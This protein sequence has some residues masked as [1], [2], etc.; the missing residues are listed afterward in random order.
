MC[1]ILSGVKV[2]N[3]HSS[4][5]FNFGCPGQ[6]KLKCPTFLIVTGR[7]RSMLCFVIFLACVLVNNVCCHNFVMIS[8]R[9]GIVPEASDDGKYYEKFDLDYGPT[10]DKVRHAGRMAGVL[11][12]GILGKLRDPDPF[13]SWLN[14]KLE[15]GP[16]APNG[17]YK[18]YYV[19]L[20]LPGLIF[21]LHM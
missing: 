11:R 12:P 14:E 21:D 7:A 8:L 13:F 5:H 17:R 16:Q 15:K 3:I 6:P 1:N 2:V 4:I 10:Y 20:S 18:P 9:G 19:S